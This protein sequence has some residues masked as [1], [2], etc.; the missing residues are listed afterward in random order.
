[1]FSVDR[2]DGRQ[3]PSKFYRK[4]KLLAGTSNTLG[5]DLVR[6]LWPSRLPNVINIA[7]ISQHNDDEIDDLLDT[8]DRVWKAMQS[9]GSRR[10]RQKIKK[11]CRDSSGGVCF[12]KMRHEISELKNLIRCLGTHDRNS[13]SKD[14]IATIFGPI[15]QTAEKKLW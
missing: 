5:D 3:N 1:M 14:R 13:R 7:C 10:I 15:D 11:K 12:S 6:K 9:S 4:I 8:A 2:R